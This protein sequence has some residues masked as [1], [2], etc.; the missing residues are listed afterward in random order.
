MAGTGKGGRQRLHPEGR[1]Y[2]VKV[3]STYS[4]NNAAP[5]QTSDAVHVA[6]LNDTAYFFHGCDG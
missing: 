3:T 1:L 5:Q 4:F 2:V 6:I